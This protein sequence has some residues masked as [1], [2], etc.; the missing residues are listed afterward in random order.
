MKLKEIS[1]YLEN[2]A[3]LAY[4][5]TYDNAGLIVGN[6]DSKVKKALICLDS[7]EEVIDEAISK[8]CNLVIAH[9]PIVFGGGLKR[10]TGKNYVERTIIKAIKNDISI[11]A[12]HTNLDNVEEGV[13]AAICKKIGLTNCKILLP[14]ENLLRKLFTFC[15]VDKA[16]A[17]RKALFEAGCGAIGDY[18]EC[19]FNVEGT[20]TFRGSESSNPYVGKKGKQ[21]HEK[22]IKIE[23]IYPVHLEG[24]ILRAL[25]SAHPYEEVAYDI[26]SLENK[27]TRVGTGMIGE[28]KKEESERAFLRR[29]KRTMQTGCIKHTKFLGTEVKRVAVCGGAGSFLLNEAIAN[30]AD[31]FITSDFRYHQFF[32]AENKIIIADIGHYESEQYTKELLYE[33][34]KKRFPKFALRLSEINTNPVNYL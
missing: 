8:G 21:H 1:N 26:V 34:L 5:E 25:L 4:Q 27:H 29:V 17:V 3:P 32:D 6:T 20:G 23:T 22:E 12:T 14:K 9:H 31:V 15:P 30:G 10:F 16:E 19:S 28:L 18:D 11:Y 33:I 13:N 7:T 24:E 2:I